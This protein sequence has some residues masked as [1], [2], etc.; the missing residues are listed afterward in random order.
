M[1]KILSITAI[2]LFSFTVLFTSCRN[3]AGTPA[4]TEE[5]TEAAP[6]TEPAP[7]DTQEAA[8]PADTTQQQA[9]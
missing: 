9:Q 1:K 7:A 8:A 5:T 6:A 3:D 2:A 4:A